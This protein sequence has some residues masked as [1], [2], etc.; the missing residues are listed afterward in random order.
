MRGYS[1]LTALL[2]K[3]TQGICVH[4]MKSASPLSVPEKH[5]APSWRMPGPTAKPLPRSSSPAS[6][7]GRAYRGGSRADRTGIVHTISRFLGWYL[8][9]H[10]GDFPG[11]PVVKNPPCN[12]GDMSLIPGWG[13]KITR[14]MEQLSPHTTRENLYTTMKEPA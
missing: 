7:T 12:A 11:G 5:D 14:A 4:Q 3:G 8:R 13:D 10:L 2:N 9:N 1:N 6:N